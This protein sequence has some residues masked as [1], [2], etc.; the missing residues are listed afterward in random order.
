[1]SRP[2]DRCSSIRSRASRYTNGSITSIRTSSTRRSTSCRSQPRVSWSILLEPV[3][4]LLVGADQG[5]D[6]LCV[7]AAHELPARDHPARYIGL[8]RASEDEREM[9]VLSRSKNAASMAS[10]GIGEHRRG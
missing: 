8:D 10:N 9:I 7:R 5:V 3:H 1:M 2:S 6:E 4:L